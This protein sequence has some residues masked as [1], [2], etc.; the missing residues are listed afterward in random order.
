MTRDNGPRDRDL[1][2]ERRGWRRN[3][4]PFSPAQEE[5]FLYTG[6]RNYRAVS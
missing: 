1:F 2:G 5:L 4:S 6:H 3:N